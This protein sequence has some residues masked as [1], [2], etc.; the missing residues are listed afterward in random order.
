MIKSVESNSEGTFCITLVYVLGILSV[1][2]N[3]VCFSYF[4]HGSYPVINPYNET[5]PNQFHTNR[6]NLHRLVIENNDAPTT[7]FLFTP[8][9]GTWYFAAFIPKK[10][11]KKITPPVSFL[12]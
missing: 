7:Y 4:Q 11:D 9:P 8:P 5:F 6:T 12:V 10:G 1:S 3:F 2:Y